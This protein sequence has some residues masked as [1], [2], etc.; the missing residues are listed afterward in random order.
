MTPKTPPRW[1]GKLLALILGLLLTPLL[2]EGILRIAA[3]AVAENRAGAKGTSLAVCQGDSFTF[4]LF[5]PPES[6]YPARLE[7]LLRDGGVAD[8]RVVNC[9]I[10]SKPTWVVKRE[11]RED[12]GAYRPRFAFL[13]AGINDHWRRRPDDH[14]VEGRSEPPQEWRVV[15]LSRWVASRLSGAGTASEEGPETAP[16]PVADPEDA[17]RRKGG[18]WIRHHE[19]EHVQEGVRTVRFQ[20]REGNPRSFDILSGEPVG[21]EFAVW[22]EED[23]TRAVEIAREE[24]AQP[25]LLSYPATGKPFDAANDA[26]EAA[27]KA[28]GAPFVD[29]RP[30]FQQAARRVGKDAL[31]FP[32]RHTTAL[33]CDLMAR[34]VL[35][36]LA[37]GGHVEL[38]SVPPVFGGLPEQTGAAELAIEIVREGDE[39]R[40]VRA[41]YQTGYGAVLLLSHTAGESPLYFV[42]RCCLGLARN[43]AQKAQATAVPLGEDPLLVATLKGN[44][45]RTLTIGADGSVLLP[46]PRQKL[47]RFAE[48]EGPVF[49]C[50]VVVLPGVGPIAAVSE[51]FE[52]ARTP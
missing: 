16:E 15:K 20:D 3:L 49:G 18:N 30:A 50:V 14:A 21:T 35:D 41:S 1:S 10:P 24:G 19:V 52:I 27:A 5:L 48:G 31:F 36:T 12:L 29:F 44:E 28:T 45:D 42:Q 33:G 8:S 40:G 13:L 7:A 34:V 23:M 9:G 39:V 22:I 47:A 37:Q 38:T 43:P 32:D 25:F 11:L 17:E 2:V 6:S 46:V 51:V 26:L 4:G